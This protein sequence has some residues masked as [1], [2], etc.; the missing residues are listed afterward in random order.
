MVSKSE[1]G[2]LIRERLEAPKK[3][4]AKKEEV[5]KI[6]RRQNLMQKQV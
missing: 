6:E 5:K 2:R 3:K 4:K 1:K